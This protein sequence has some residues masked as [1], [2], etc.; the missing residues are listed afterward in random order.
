MYILIVARGYPNKNNPLRGIFEFDQAK[1]LQSFGNK[2]I[3]ISLDLRSIRR[4]RKLGKYWTVVEGINILDISVPLG[5]IPDGLRYNI[6]KLGLRLYYKEILKRN[7]K[8][9]IIHAHFSGIGFMASVLKEKFNIPLVITEHSSKITK[10]PPTYKQKKFGDW[11]YSNADS[12][13][14]VSSLLAKNLKLHWNIN[15]EIVHN[16]VDTNSF[17]F[18]KRNTTENFNFLTVGN[19][20]SRKG[21]D[22]SIEAFKKANFNKNIQ[23]KIIGEG[24]ERKKLQTQIDKLELKNQIKL[25]GFLNRDE[26]S[27]V[28]Q[29]SD[30][31]VLA[32]RGETFGVVYIEAML[33]GLPVIATA[34]GGPED[35]VTFENGILIPVNDVNALTQA[36]KKMYHSIEKFNKKAISENSKKKFSPE[37]IAN[38]LTEI[39]RKTL[40]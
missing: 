36:L 9:D 12:I 20:I 7:G 37:N 19:L 32:S 8:P 29:E 30:A 31:F 26:I 25:L 2:V 16:I 3:Y 10:K 18:N 1:A 33:A 17:F 27:K 35:F 38:N 22:I 28:M 40:K 4:K 11:I 6:G 34:C 15:A 5:K 39:Y 14:A 13:I 21:F 23:L 24:P